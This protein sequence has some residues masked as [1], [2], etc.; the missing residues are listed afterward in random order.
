MK[1]DETERTIKLLHQLRLDPAPSEVQP[2]GWYSAFQTSYFEAF[3]DASINT[4][5]ADILQ[6]QGERS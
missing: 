3:A 6:E 1:N 5:A 4:A 2:I